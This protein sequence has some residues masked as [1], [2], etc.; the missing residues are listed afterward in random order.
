MKRV[1]GLLVTAALIA[2]LAGCAAHSD[3]GPT[4]PVEYELTMSSMEGGSVM[5]PGEGTFTYEAGAVVELVA[6]AEEGRRFVNWTGDTATIADQYLASSTITMN[7]DYSVTASFGYDGVYFACPNLEAAIREAIDTPEGPIY[8]GDLAE[9]TMLTAE[10]RGISDLTG[11]GCVTNIA[12]LRLSGNN[13]AD[14]S[15]V[16]RLTNLT[17]IQLQSNQIR[18]ISPLESL[19]NLTYLDLRHNQIRDI[20]PLESLTNLTSLDLWGNQIRDILPLQ[21]L[22][23]LAVLYLQGNKIGDLSPL[24][25]LTKLTVLCLAATGTSDLSPL[26]GLIS[27]TYLYLTSNQI[28]D[29]SPLSGL[30][31]LT[32]LNLMGNQVSDISPLLENDGLVDGAYVILRFNPLSAASR[33]THVP[34]LRARGVTVD[35]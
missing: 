25:G 28:S 31:G 23:N 5:V 22:T 12:E 16:Q 13:I 33:N 9:L 7:G 14:I 6:V 10:R 18:D 15:P 35:Y 2:G 3:A 8:P 11:L 19:T 20:S 26:A 24:Q 17:Y 1:V 32:Y 30:T 27:L 29:L 21:G 4:P 34:E